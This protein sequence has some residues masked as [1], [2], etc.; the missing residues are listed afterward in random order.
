MNGSGRM[1]VIERKF[2]ERTYQK[3]MAYF[4]EG[5]V[6]SLVDGDSIMGQAIGRFENH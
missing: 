2:G 1:L 6:V 4:K 3:E 5:R